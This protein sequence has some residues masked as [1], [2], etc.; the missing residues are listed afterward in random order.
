MVSES[1][2]TVNPALDGKNVDL[3]SPTVREGEGRRERKKRETSVFKQ[4]ASGWEARFIFK[5]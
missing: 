1:K 5:A 4:A 2:D 3:A